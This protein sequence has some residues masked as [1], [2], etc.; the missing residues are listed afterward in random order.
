VGGDPLLCIMNDVTIADPRVQALKSGGHLPR[1]HYQLG[2]EPVVSRMVY[3]MELLVDTY[4]YPVNAAAGI[5]GNLRAESG[6]LPSRIE[7]SADATPMRS[8]NFAN[9][10]TDFSPVR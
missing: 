10:M 5:V 8:R 2:R 6:V 9:V 3:V 1:P 7:G 4:H